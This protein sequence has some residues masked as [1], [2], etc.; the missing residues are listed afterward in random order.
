M[1]PVYDDNFP[2]PIHFHHGLFILIMVTVILVVLFIIYLIFKAFTRS[3][4]EAED[5]FSSGHTHGVF[6]SS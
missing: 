3:S 2:K 1:T 4:D 6:G 5:A